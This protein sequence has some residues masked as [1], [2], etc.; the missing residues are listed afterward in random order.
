[1][2]QDA[3]P[4]APPTDTPVLVDGA[5]PDAAAAA[6]RLAAAHGAVEGADGAAS[7]VALVARRPLPGVGMLPRLA[8]PLRARAVAALLDGT[9]D[10]PPAAPAV[11][12]SL[13]LP[14]PSVAPGAF[15]TEASARNAGAA[16]L[17]ASPRAASAS[18]PKFSAL[19]VEDNAINQVLAAALLERLGIASTVVADGERA[20][21]QLKTGRWD[22]VLMDC[23]MPV[24]DGYEAIRRW[25]EIEHAQGLPRTPVIALTANA[26]EGDR[27]RCIAAGM[28]DYLS[29]PID[30]A[31]LAARLATWL[32]G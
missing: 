5:R 7:R 9:P 23:Q 10:A 29:K 4:D 26:M 15:G 13:G 31:A 18:P 14:V 3:D 8:W 24:M 22:V 1:V 32:P 17:P 6:A 12:A 27:D 30:R 21:E 20:L 28:D 25:R 16:G 11:R 19:V 2:V